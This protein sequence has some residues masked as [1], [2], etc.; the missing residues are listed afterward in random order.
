[1]LKDQHDFAMEEI[2]KNT[3][4]VTKIKKKK[5]LRDGYYHTFQSAI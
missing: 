3:K 1:M 5:C 4:L 2:G